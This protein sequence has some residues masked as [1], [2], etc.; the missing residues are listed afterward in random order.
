MPRTISDA[1]RECGHLKESGFYL[2]SGSLSAGGNLAPWTWA[3]GEGVIGGANLSLTVPPRLT[4][5]IHLAATLQ[6]GRVTQSVD[7]LLAFGPPLDRLAERPL[8]LADHVGSRYYTP[9]QFAEECRTRGA[10]RHVTLE[11]AKLVAG[12]LPMPILF[13]HK[14]MPY[15]DRRVLDEMAEWV[16]DPARMS[17][18]RTYDEPDWGITAKDDHGDDHWIISLLHLLN[19]D[20]KGRNKPDLLKLMPPHLAE[21]ILWN[22]QGIGI[23]WIVDAVY[24]IAEDDSDAKL[25][26]I[27][28]MGIEPVLRGED[29]NE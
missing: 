5:P 19:R 9:M 23:S 20:G 22:E 21:S 29:A 27:A 24:V 13:T 3:L 15:V 1:P 4:I 14:D 8:A 25:N 28:D 7:P 18:G 16:G 6:S 17:F 26:Y 10:S 11:L 2:T 12:R